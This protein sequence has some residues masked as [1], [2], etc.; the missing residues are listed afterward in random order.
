MNPSTASP[1]NPFADDSIIDDSVNDNELNLNLSQEV[2]HET[3]QE[4]TDSLHM[5]LVETNIAPMPISLPPSPPKT[6]S[7]EF[8][9]SLD[10]GS[11]G[12]IYTLD[13]QQKQQLS[14]MSPL[15]LVDEDAKMMPTTPPRIPP[16]PAPPAPTTAMRTAT[17]NS[18]PTIS[19]AEVSKNGKPPKAESKKNGKKKKKKPKDK[20][21]KKNANKDMNKKAKKAKD[22]DGIGRAYQEQYNTTQKPPPSARSYNGT[23]RSKIVNYNDSQKKERKGFSIFRLFPYKPPSS[24]KPQVNSWGKN[25]G[26][27][28]RSPRSGWNEYADQNDQFRPMKINI[29]ISNSA[30]GEGTTV[31]QLLHRMRVMTLIL[32][33]LTIA[34]ES[35]ALIIQAVFLQANKVIL[36]AFLLF[37]IGLLLC[38]ELVRGTP[39]PY[40]IAVSAGSGMP[41]FDE[42]LVSGGIVQQS[43][44]QSFN[45]AANLVDVVWRGALEE[46]WAR[47]L[48]Y[49]LQDNFGIFY[50]CLGRG[51][52]FFFL[53]SLAW[54]QQF[55][56]IRAIGIAFMMMGTWTI[57]LK[58]RY[59]AF[60][61][62]LM[63]E[64]DYEFGESRAVEVDDVGEGSVISW[65]SVGGSNRSVGSPS[66]ERRSLLS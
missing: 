41:L 10:G 44:N 17:T 33:G 61:K 22:Q 34:F 62:V 50:S 26:L 27:D 14:Q 43:L 32:S 64:L 66:G 5:H 16:E 37:F 55:F 47:R 15:P 24:P 54:G 29:G 28:N 35:W 38:V 46:L 36:G 23:E 1:F 20:Q 8:H 52:L 21:K 18:T 12:G 53:G 58:F 3:F 13:Q 30:D 45:N 7:R 25:P 59:P 11:H 39:V 9:D 42:R 48:R 6:P 60:D 57:S 49:F 31:P 56:V 4:P 63:M 19:I 40:S 51:F 65:S 2:Y